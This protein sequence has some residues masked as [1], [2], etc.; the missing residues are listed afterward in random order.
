MDVLEPEEKEAVIV[1]I[2]EEVKEELSFPLDE[3]RTLCNKYSELIT[4]CEHCYRA[5]PSAPNGGTT[6]QEICAREISRLHLPTECLKYLGIFIS[7]GHCDEC[8]AVIR[9]RVRRIVQQKEGNPDCYGKRTPP[10]YFCDQAGC[11]HKDLCLVASR[12][13]VE[14]PIKWRYAL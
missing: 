4:Q 1:I 14:S 8:S 3:F 6:P 10:A 9:Q 11:I 7:H 13:K 5:W 2:Q 12:A